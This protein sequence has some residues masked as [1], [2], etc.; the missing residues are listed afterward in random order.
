[1]DRRPDTGGPGIESKTGTVAC[2]QCG[3][4]SSLLWDGWRACRIDDP[5]TTEPPALAFFCPSCARREF[6]G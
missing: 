4:P 5:E 6:D 3:C 2:A 1:V